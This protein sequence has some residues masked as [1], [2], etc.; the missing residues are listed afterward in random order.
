[1]ITSCENKFIFSQSTYS[2]G[3]YKYE[4]WGDMHEERSKTGYACEETERG[5]EGEDCWKIV[6]KQLRSQ[7]SGNRR[8]SAVDNAI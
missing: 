5:E 3:D 4:L 6:S 1:M 8:G 7:S 2:T